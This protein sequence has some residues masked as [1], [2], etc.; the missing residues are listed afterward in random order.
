MDREFSKNAPYK[1]KIIFHLALSDEMSQKYFSFCL[2]GRSVVHNF[3]FSSFYRELKDNE[4]SVTFHMTGKS[5]SKLFHGY[6]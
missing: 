2:D 6:V 5:H 1:Q 3:I 4:A